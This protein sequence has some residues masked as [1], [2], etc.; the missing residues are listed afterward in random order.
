VHDTG[1]GSLAARHAD[2]PLYGWM[3]QASVA[4]FGF[5]R[6]AWIA[7]GFAAWGLLAWAASRLHR[8]VFPESPGWSWLPALLVVS[9]VVVQTQFATLTIAYPDVLPVALVLGGVVTASGDANRRRT[10]VG[11]LL[12][13][14]AAAISE[15]GVAAAFAGAGPRSR[16]AAPPDGALPRRWGRPW[17]PWSFD[18]PP[19]P[20]RGPTSP[21]TRCCCPRSPPRRSR[22][23]TGGSPESGTR[24]PAPGAA[25]SGA[26][27][28]MRSR[29]ARSRSP[30]W[31]SRAP[32][33]PCWPRRVRR[34]PGGRAR[35]PRARGV[36]SSSSSP[37]RPRSFPSRAAG[38]ATV[39]SA[40]WIGEYETRFLLPALPFASVLL[41]GTI[42]RGMTPRAASAAAALLAFLCV[43]A[44]W[45]GARQAMSSERWAEQLG[46]ALLP[47]V[48][49]TDGIVIAVGEDDPTLR[50]GSTL[51][52]KTTR[53]WRDDDARRVWVMARSTAR[54]VFG[55]RPGCRLPETIDFD[56]EIRGIRR[57]GRLRSVLWVAPAGDRVAP[58]EPYCLA[59]PSP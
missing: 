37:S 46:R 17:A 45:D 2:R 29:A 43:E 33:S 51:T 16:S 12:A 49:S 31:A 40:A 52:G 39:F 55:A 44:S 8:L 47:V 35:R 4:A 15:Y 10:V 18:S 58:F 13:A 50:W 59:A 23:C 32:S 21:P 1:A 11:F 53:S 7:V 41:S 56:A 14:L 5:H 22:A 9:P 48:R 24:R 3:L 28:S 54:R 25:R 6:F 26:R 42:A 38:R 20:P 36:S 30:R 57:S 34:A 19:T 27:S